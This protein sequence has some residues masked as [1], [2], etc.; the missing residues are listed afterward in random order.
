MVSIATCNSLQSTSVTRKKACILNN[1]ANDDIH[2]PKNPLGLIVNGLCFSPDK[3]FS[4][5]CMSA[6]CTTLT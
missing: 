6:K 5:R 1:Y 2:L 3:L 4:M